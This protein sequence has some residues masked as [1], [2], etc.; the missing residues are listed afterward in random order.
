MA[1]GAFGAAL[2]AYAVVDLSGKAVGVQLAGDA[3]GGFE[4]GGALVILEAE[5][6]DGDKHGGIRPPAGLSDTRLGSPK[7]SWRWIGAACA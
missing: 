7:V 3:A 1:V 5:G 6:P 2:H 4:Q